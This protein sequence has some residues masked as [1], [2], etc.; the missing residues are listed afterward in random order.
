MKNLGI[1][2]AF[3]I[4][5]DFSL[6]PNI[7]H[8]DN[9]LAA[10][11]QLDRVCHVRLTLSDSQ[12]GRIATP[13]Q[14][15]FPVLKCLYITSLFW[16]EV[17]PTLPAG[18]LGGSAPRLQAI[19]LCS[20]PYPALPTLLSSTSDL[21]KLE[22]KNIPLTGYISPSAMVA[23]LAALQKLEIFVMEFHPYDSRPD[24]IGP[25]PVTRTV[26]PALTHF[27]FRGTSE[28]LEDFV[29]R[30]DGPRLNHIS[31]TTLYRPVGFQVPQ[32]SRF[33]DHSVGPKLSQCKHAEVLFSHRFLYRTVTL[34]SSHRPD[35]PD[36]DRTTIISYEGIDW[37][38]T[39]VSQ[40][41]SQFPV[42]LS[43]V[44][45][46]QIK[47]TPEKYPS[48]YDSLSWIVSWFDLFRQFSAMQT[49]LVPGQVS[50]FVA[51]I[52]GRPS[53][54]EVMM[55][56][57]LPSLELL[58]LEEPCRSVDKFIAARQLSGHPVTVV[59]TIKEFRE[60]LESYMNKNE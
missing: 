57:G 17:V 16:C 29:G 6:H 13:M 60:R 24:R 1:W 27:V 52:L 36:Q 56:E 30:I 15:P 31:I 42:T 51:N 35:D 14:E 33:V 40:V 3:P 20:I 34:K 54:T 59:N 5:V 21:V 32:L 25:F 48:V 45:H 58:C 7:L 22:L 44:V 43:N 39:P 41:L 37:A 8:E 4:D 46:L 10:F 11:K 2:P 23:S 55:T 49:L 12:V 26:L 47:C 38:T 19:G 18:F 53:I 9:I 28:Y 50:A